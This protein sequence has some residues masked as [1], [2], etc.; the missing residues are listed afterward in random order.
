MRYIDIFNGDADGILSLLQLRLAQPR[1]SLLV[2]GV[3][4]DNQ[5]MNNLEY[6]AEDCITVLDI[7]MLKNISGLQRALECGASVEYFDHHQAGD[8]PQHANLQATI[9]TAP[10][11]CTALLV[12]Q[13]LEG[14]YHHWAIAAAYG[15]NLVK[16]ADALANEARLSIGRRNALKELGILINYN[17]YGTNVSD[18]HFEP[19]ILFKKLL[20]YKS[21]F[22]VIED[23]N[24][25]YHELK[26]A[27]KNDLT[28]ARG[29]TPYYESSSVKVVV[30]PNLPWA[31]RISGVFGNQLANEAPSQAQLV[32][33]I[34]T[35]TE[36]SVSLR[37][38]V[39]SPVG[40]VDICSTYKTGGG[41]QE[42]QE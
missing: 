30:L 15:D 35:D 21:P 19:T 1:E 24:S 33:T 25:P 29:I 38:P 20:C 18:L 5:L 39:L 6:Q 40:A 12:D 13:H 23:L 28:L 27:Y 17:G 31:R 26:I 41:E 10:D 37:A 36:A 34:S 22:E 9:D 4:R 7:S 42:R 14:R 11:V 3:K 32:L 8:I 2:T 16:T